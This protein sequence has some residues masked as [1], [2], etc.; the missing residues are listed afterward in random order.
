MNKHLFV[1]NPTATSTHELELY[2]FLGVIMGVSVRTGAYLSLDLPSLVWKRLV[3][4]KITIEDL[5]QVDLRFTMKMRQI[6]GFTDENCL[7]DINGYVIDREKQEE[8][9]IEWAT[10]D[11]EWTA[12]Y[13]DGCT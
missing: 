3:G 13:S 4:Q 11:L 8:S 6:L 10:L 7:V 12:M 1:L 5:E 2:E 9:S